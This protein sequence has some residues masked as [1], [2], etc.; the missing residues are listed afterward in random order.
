VA[1]SYDKGETWVVVHTWEGNCPRVGAPGTVTNIYDVNQDYTFTIPERFPTGHRVI[2][3]WWVA[4]YMASKYA[5]EYRVW[6]NASGNREYYMSC[7]SV[8][9]VGTGSGTQTTPAGPPLLVANLDPIRSECYTKEQTSVIYPRKYTGDA[10]IQRA[11]VAL[12]LQVF[13]AP[14][15]DG[16]GSDNLTLIELIKGSPG[17]VVSGCYDD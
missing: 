17:G 6:I 16:C 9:V 1:F 12:D 5:Y 3:A 10:P 13:P 8:D 2:F 4:Q 7:T 14:N 11:P 15:L